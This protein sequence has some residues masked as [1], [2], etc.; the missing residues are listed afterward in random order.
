MM[1]ETAPGVAAGGNVWQMQ[2]SYND[3]KSCASHTWEPI[4]LA[5][6]DLPL[7]VRAVMR[8]WEQNHPLQRVLWAPSSPKCE[9]LRAPG[10]TYAW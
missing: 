9:K 1:T 3:E 2:S 8:T 6:N 4:R 7:Q 10:V 5:D